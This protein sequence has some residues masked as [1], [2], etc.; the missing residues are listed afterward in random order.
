M[1]FLPVRKRSTHSAITN[2][3]ITVASAAPRTSIFSAKMNTGSRIRLSTVPIST[4]PMP[5]VANP[6]MLMNGFIPRLII[7]KAVPIR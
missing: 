2:W 7:V 5:V 4:V 6:C 3:L 1:A